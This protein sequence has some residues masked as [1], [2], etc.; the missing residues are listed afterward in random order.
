MFLI[1]CIIYI[2]LLILLNIYLSFGYS[3]MYVVTIYINNAKIFKIK[4]NIPELSFRLK[5]VF[6]CHICILNIFTENMSISA[7]L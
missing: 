5:T 7:V 6:F 3:N 4:N 2:I 1:I